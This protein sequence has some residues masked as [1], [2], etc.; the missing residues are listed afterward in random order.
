M[1]R[2]AEL[3]G[4]WAG[5]GRGPFQLFLPFVSPLIIQKHLRQKSKGKGATLLVDNDGDRRSFSLLSQL[6]KRSSY[7]YTSKYKRI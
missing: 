5:V 2:E 6:R 7:N 1:V 4:S 3:T